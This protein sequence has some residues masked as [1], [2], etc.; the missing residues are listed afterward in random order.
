VGILSYDDKEPLPIATLPLG[1]SYTSFTL[2]RRAIINREAFIWER[3]AASNSSQLIRS[4]EDV[5]TAIYA[6]MIYNLDVVGVLYVNAT[7]P[8]ERFT[9]RDLQILSEIAGCT[10]RLIVEHKS[11]QLSA[12]P[13]VFISYSHQDRTFVDQLVGDLR[14]GSV[15]VWYDDRLLV[16]EEWRKE[17]QIAIEV[18][19]TFILVM[20]PA[21]IASENVQWEVERAQAANKLILPILYQ[22]CTPPTWLNEIQYVDIRSDYDKSLAELVQAARAPRQ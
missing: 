11:V 18:M 17:L 5:T 14:R 3:T 2:A 8:D 19:D 20:S 4:L 16:G 1:K 21:S 22:T 6:P 15:S 7:S 12:F 13:S 9:G 10:A